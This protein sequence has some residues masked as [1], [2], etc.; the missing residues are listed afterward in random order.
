M[1]PSYIAE[2]G[3]TIPDH[4]AREQAVVPGAFQ[5]R[6]VEIRAEDEAAVIETEAHVVEEI[7]IRKVA[8]DRVRTVRETVRRTEV[9][10]ENDTPRR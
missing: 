9:D 6:V 2:A 7:V 5:E 1:F 3:M 10:V 8:A 4:D